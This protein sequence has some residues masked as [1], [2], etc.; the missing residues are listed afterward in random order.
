MRLATLHANVAIPR[1]RRR[2]RH[3][4]AQSGGG[5]ESLQKSGRNRPIADISSNPKTEGRWSTTA[6]RI[7]GL[8]A[9]AY[10]NLAFDDHRRVERQYGHPG[11]GTRAHCCFRT[12]Q[13]NH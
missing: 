5:L 13:L 6:H 4:A 3:N 8:R 7:K 2:R 9:R 11:D 12:E 10:L 1:A